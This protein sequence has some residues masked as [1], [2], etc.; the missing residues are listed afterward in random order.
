MLVRDAGAM[1]ASGQYRCSGCNFLFDSQ[2][3]WREG[4]QGRA[5]PAT[6]S[7]RPALL[8][9]ALPVTFHRSPSLGRMGAALAGQS[10]D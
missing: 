6:P 2:A 10:D 5:V 1:K 8:S 4:G 9:S 7:R 3:S